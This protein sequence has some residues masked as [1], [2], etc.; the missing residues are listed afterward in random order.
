LALL[1]KVGEESGWTAD[2]AAGIAWSVPQESRRGSLRGGV[3][4]GASSP[5]GKAG[6]AMPLTL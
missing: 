1:N 6:L 3:G 4:P 2:L 5:P